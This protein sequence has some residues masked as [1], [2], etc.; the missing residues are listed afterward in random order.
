M[1]RDFRCAGYPTAPAHVARSAE[2]GFQNVVLTRLDLPPGALIPDPGGALCGACAAAKSVDD[3]STVNV[4]RVLIGNIRTKLRTNPVPQF[5]IAET[6][7]ILRALFG[8]D[9]ADNS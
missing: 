1:S 7:L 6:A 2:L 4:K 8:Q 3:N 9:D 5:T